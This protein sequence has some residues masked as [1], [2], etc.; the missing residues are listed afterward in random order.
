MTARRTSETGDLGVAGVLGPRM[1]A[2]MN[3]QARPGSRRETP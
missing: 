1:A 2:S 3:L